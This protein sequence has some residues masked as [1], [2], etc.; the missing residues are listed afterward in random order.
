MIC[1]YLI[2]CLSTPVTTGAIIAAVLV[3]VSVVVMVVLVVVGAIVCSRW[4]KKRAQNLDQE[5]GQVSGT[6]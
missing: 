6:C 5:S 1:L 2:C 3:T 4:R